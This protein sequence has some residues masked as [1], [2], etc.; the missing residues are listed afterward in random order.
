MKVTRKVLSV[1]LSVLIVVS[2]FMTVP[3]T[4]NSATLAKDLS[5]E[6]NYNGGITITGY[7]GSDTEVIIPS[8]IDGKSVTEIGD[9]AFRDCP[10]LTTVTI[11]NGVTSIGRYAFMRCTGLTSIIIPDSVTDI[12]YG[13]FMYC[14]G[15]TSIT[16]PGSVTS[17]G[18]SAFQFCA[19]L[20]SITIPDSVTDIGSDAFYYCTGLTN[21]E[22]DENNKTYSSQDG[23]LFNKEKTQLI[24]FPEGKTGTLKISDIVTSIDFY[25]LDECQKLTNIEVDL[26][27][28]TYASQDGVLYNKEKTS[29]IKCPA[30]KTGTLVI[31]DG[32]TDIIQLAFNGCEELTNITLPDSITEI[33]YF[34]F[35]GCYGLTSI[36]IPDSV[37]RIRNQAFYY[38]TGLTSVTIGKSVTSIGS[39]AFEYCENLMSIEVDQDNKIYESQDGVLYNIGKILVLFPAGRTG[40][41]TIPNGVIGIGKDAFGYCER[42]TSIIIPNSVTSIGSS[43]F[44]NCTGLTSVTIPDSV[45]DIENYAFEFCE[46]LT[47]INIPNSVTNIGRDV[48]E[49]CKNLTIYGYSGSYAETYA[50]ENDIPFVAID[51]SLEDPDTKITVTGDIDDNVELNVSEINVDEINIGDNSKIAVV[52]FDI[53]LIQ[54]GKEIQPNGLVS[55][56]IP[57]AGNYNNVEVYRV[58]SD[59]TTEKM[60]SSY[61]GECVSFTTDHFSKYAIVAEDETGLL[62][63]VNLDGAI[64]VADATLVQMSIADLSELSDEESANADVNSDGK[65]N[66]EDATL[67][68]MFAA[69]LIDSFE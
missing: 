52:C 58:N 29:L 1:L 36:T 46:N 15:L 38:C 32:V 16:I 53:T 26:N 62:G 68:Q 60:Q 33:G 47:S 34:T 24:K 67:I 43:A 56:K 49:Y 6:E 65:I 19:G 7:N 21:I 59:G 13:A 42:L 12:D 14:S 23:V 51:N 22:V 55:V 35:G 25:A 5:Y 17:I 11:G 40:A 31:P 57:F 61:N 54:N 9:S 8:E 10:G 20:T 48:F 2:V 18:E 28:Q 64:N 50:N 41:F 4:V 63:D 30:G 69:N 44:F 27:N 37:K 39:N 3:F 66:V 45:T